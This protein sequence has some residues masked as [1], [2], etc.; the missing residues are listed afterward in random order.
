[1]SKSLNAVVSVVQ[2]IDMTIEPFGVGVSV[3]A[4]EALDPVNDVIEKF[5]YVMFVSTLSLGV[6]KLFAEVGRCAFVKVILAIV[7]MLIILL[8]LI[9]NAPARDNVLSVLT[10]TLII[11]VVLRFAMPVVSTLNKQ[12]YDSVIQQ[13][14]AIAEEKLTIL[15]DEISNMDIVDLSD[16]SA[17]KNSDGIKANTEPVTKNQKPSSSNE[18]G[19]MGS[20]G[21]MWN[22]AVEK[23]GG[24]YGNTTESMA[25]KWKGF[26]GM[27]D[28]Q[29]MKRK[30][31]K[32]TKK[33]SE[34]S[35]Y[36]MNLAV[37][38]VFQTIVSPLLV[39]WG[40]VKMASYLVRSRG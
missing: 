38:F 31:D 10:K 19:L 25:N 11:F 30:I 35:T 18:A 33:V 27:V 1:M 36:L 22:S 23:T 13:N 15:A 37:I 9:D 39:L 21:K 14:M 17:S 2:D 20:V 4:G 29:E 8:L 5:S 24:V 16:G 28:P 40:L 3:G 6:Q 32:L 34:A 12:V 26:K 7:S